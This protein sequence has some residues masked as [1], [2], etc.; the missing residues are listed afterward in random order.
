VLEREV[1]ERLSL[2][3]ELFGNTP[4]E[5]GGRCDMAFNVG[6]TLKLC[7]HVN[8]LFA[9]GRDIVG[10]TRAMVYLGLQVLTN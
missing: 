3:V 8:L 5:R 6:G 10:E 2:G 1:N 4:K 7:T 9:T